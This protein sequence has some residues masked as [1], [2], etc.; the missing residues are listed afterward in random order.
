MSYCLCHRFCAV[1]L[2]LTVCVPLRLVPSL[3]WRDF[4]FRHQHVHASATLDDKRLPGD[5]VD[6]S[7]DGS[8]AVP[9]AETEFSW[10]LPSVHYPRIRLLLSHQGP[11][12]LKMRLVH[13]LY[14]S[15]A[16]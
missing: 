13:T 11:I 16:I 5:V 14:A 6:R 7:S 15:S 4:T 9:E 3:N 1:G 8:R 2:L 12:Y 10:E